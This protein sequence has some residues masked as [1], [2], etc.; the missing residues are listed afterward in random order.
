MLTHALHVKQT[1][2]FI[3]Q[4]PST[5][6][7]VRTSRVG[8]GRGGSKKDVPLTLSPQ[9]MRKVGSTRVSS[10][11]QTNSTDGNL[12]IPQQYLIAL[13]DADIERDDQFT[14]EGIPYKV[15]SVNDEPPWRKQAS[16]V[17]QV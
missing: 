7:L 15:Q 5:I 1:E 8:D 2:A 6:V 11:S 9:T 3:G 16:I 4:N 14:L 12:L 13:P 17:E 10:T